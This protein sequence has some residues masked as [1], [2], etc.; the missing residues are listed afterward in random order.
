MMKPFFSK[1]C[2]VNASKLEEEETAMRIPGSKKNMSPVKLRLAW[3]SRG[4]LDH[5]VESG[6]LLALMRS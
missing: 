5:L 6:C 3:A 1:R 4:Q 2:D